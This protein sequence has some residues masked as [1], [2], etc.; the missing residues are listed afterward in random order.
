MTHLS[1]TDVTRVSKEYGVPNGHGFNSSVLT[2][3]PNISDTFSFQKLPQI[4]M[5]IDKRLAIVM[6][7]AGTDFRRKGLSRKMG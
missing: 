1:G 5:S 6:R 3:S 4:L 7:R 2:I